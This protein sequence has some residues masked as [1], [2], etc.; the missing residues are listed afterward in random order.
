MITTLGQ[1]KKFIPMLL[2]ANICPYIHSSPGQGKSA[3]ARQIAADLNLKFIDIRLSDMEPSDIVGLPTFTNGR[4]HF[5]PFTTFPIDTD[6]IPEGYE[7]WLI[8]CDEF[9]SGNQSVQAA[10]YRLILDRQV[11]QYDLH[12]KAFLMAA[13]NLETDN[14]I[15]NPMGSALISRF[16]H[17]YIETSHK[18]WMEWASGKLDIRVTS[19]IGRF[20][21]H[22]NTFNPDAS[23]PYSCQRT[24][25]ML[26]DTINGRKLDA[27][28]I[29]LI[30]SLVG[31]GIANEFLAFSSLY[32]DLPEF[33]TIVDE[34]E[35]TPVSE[36]MSIRWA[37][38]GLVAH[39]IDKT[40]A[41]Q[42]AT[43]LKRLPIEL[44]I[45]ALREIKARNPDLLYNEISDWALEVAKKI[46]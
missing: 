8:L 38:M 14:A 6:T 15:V 4:A 9:S 42:C 5:T 2:E 36:N 20:P 43:Y 24:F 1:I 35:T 39:S 40:N 13:G 46:F 23:K 32:S 28:Y 7:G 31:E 44:Q 41:K 3:F 30:A 12:P 17:F 18:E 19:F 16:A 34:P 33:Q 22:L 45:C 25:H 11:G 29:P 26:S 10:A 37:V 27:S 21:R